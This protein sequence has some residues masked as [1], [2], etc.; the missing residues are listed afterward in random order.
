MI[1]VLALLAGC[2]SAP[3]SPAT[4]STIVVHRQSVFTVNPWDG[5]VSRADARSGALQ[6]EIELGAE[7]TRM[8]RLGEELWVTLRASREVVVLDI[9]GDGAPV[10]TAR[11]KVGAEPYGVAA[12]SDGSLVYV[13]VSQ[14]DQVV[15]FDAA[16]RKELRRW[17]VMDDPRW[18]AMH[19]CDCALFVA[20]AYDAPLGRIDLENGEVTRIE[21]PR[22][23]LPQTDGEDPVVLTPR[24]TGDIAISP[25][26]DAI[27]WPVLYVDNRSPGEQPEVSAAD[28]TPPT[29]PYYTGATTQIG[30]Q[31]SISKFNP[32]LVGLPLETGSGEPVDGED[33]IAVFVGG[34]ANGLPQR[35]YLT[36]AVFDRN[37]TTVYAPMESAN[38][39]AAVDLRPARGQRMDPSLDAD[40]ATA[41]FS[42]TAATALAPSVGNFYERSQGFAKLTGNPYAVALDAAGRVFVHQ[43]GGRIASQLHRGR[44]QAYLDRLNDGVFEVA[45][46]DPISSVPVARRRTTPAFEDGRA[47]FLAADDPRMVAIGA[48][49]SCS[50]CH[51][52]GRND[53]L[54]WSFDHDPRQTPSI[55][56]NVGET[57]PVTWTQEVE[58]VAREAQITALGRMGGIGLSNEEAQ[59]LEGFVDTLRRV[60]VERLGARDAVVER[61][62]AL[63]FDETVGCAECHAG[64]RGT[65]RAKHRV[66]DLAMEV[67]TPT[68]T[69]I[70]ATA[71]YLHDGTAPTLRAV[72]ERVRDGS[73]GDTSGLSNEDMEALVAYLRTL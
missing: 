50:T 40:A 17:D 58:T 16:A 69:G 8:I 19:P 5:T 52:E 51:F 35:S 27:V 33:S 26:G 21:P 61:G 24:N 54:T 45:D 3:P 63:F 71:P 37:G 22:T 57:A 15:E 18:L 66:L 44:I 13:A 29:N 41:F 60:D 59:K 64:P 43:R 39:V 11:L 2:G 14:Q 68:L 46:F 47:M 12:T 42:D 9:S 62:E 38:A 1:S 32:S 7:P 73:M 30:L 48:G 53:G 72:L 67:D 56:G 28:I 36:G 10:E 20:S 65:D 4:G 70:D 34:F 31:L 49:V 6:G 55:A 23:E 25:I